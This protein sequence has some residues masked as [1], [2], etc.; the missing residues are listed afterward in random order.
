MKCPIMLKVASF[1]SRHLLGEELAEKEKTTHFKS[2]VTGGILGT[3]GAIAGGIREGAEISGGT[4]AGVLLGVL[5]SS[6]INKIKR[7]K[8]IDD[9]AKQHGLERVSTEKRLLGNKYKIRDG[10]DIY[11]MKI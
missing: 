4:L 2:V 1:E 11:D 10:R 5:A 7:E 9:I 3:G 8:R 6:I